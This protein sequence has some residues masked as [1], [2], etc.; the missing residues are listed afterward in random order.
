MLVSIVAAAIAATS[1]CELAQLTR[2]LSCLT[3]MRAFASKPA[4]VNFSYS[5]QKFLTHSESCLSY[6]R[7]KGENIP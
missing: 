1:S 2:F 3:R 4:S 7:D 6:G 5:V